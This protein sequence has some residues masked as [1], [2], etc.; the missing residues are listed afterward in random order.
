[1]TPSLSETLAPPSTTT[2]GPLGV[3]GELAQHLDLGHDQ[4]ARRVRQQPGHVVDAGVLAVHRAEAV[5]DVEL[6][7]RRPACSA[8]APR[9]GVVLGLLARLEAQVLQQ[10]DL[11]VL[12][13]L[14]TTLCALVADHV[15]GEG[16]VLAEQLAQPRGR[17]GAA[18]TS[19][20]AA[21]LGRPRWAQTMTFAPALDQRLIVGTDARMR[22]SSVIVSPS[23]GTLRS[24]R[25]STRRFREIVSL[26]TLVA[27]SSV[28]RTH[29]RS[30]PTSSMRSTRRL[31]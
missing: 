25:T 18:S 24:A 4:P 17:P 30:A 29:Q 3:L 20:S 6:G 27:S 10:G 23:R 1:M 22:P 15:G 28:V 21:P 2:Y 7:E 8:N 16:H 9:V 5:A 31:E 13:R 12:Q 14:A 11:A 26:R 19:G